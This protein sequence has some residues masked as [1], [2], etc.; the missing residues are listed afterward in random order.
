[1]VRKSGVV[2][3]SEEIGWP[4]MTMIGIWGRCWRTIRMVSNPSIPGMKMSRNN[5]SKSPVSA[6]CQPLSPVAG[7]D[8]AMAGAFQQQADGHLDRRIVIHDQYLAKVMVLRPPPESY[9]RQ[10]AIFAETSFVLQRLHRLA[11]FRQL[12]GSMRK[13]P[14]YPHVV[15]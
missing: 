5:R 9:Q 2:S 6:Q 11:M 3:A 8:H 4:E 12:V 13:K 7:G 10:V 1:M 14:S 15:G